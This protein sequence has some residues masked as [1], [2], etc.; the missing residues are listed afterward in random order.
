[1]RPRSV[2]SSTLLSHGQEISHLSDNDRSFSSSCLVVYV[3]GEVRKL[4]A[5][6]RIK[7]REEHYICEIKPLL[8]QPPPLLSPLL[9]FP[10][11]PPLTFLY[12]WRRRRRLGENCDWMRRGGGICDKGEERRKKSPTFSHL[13][14][15]SKQLPRLSTTTILYLLYHG[16]PCS[17]PYKRL[18]PNVTAS[19]PL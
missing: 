7:S 9:P 8:F 13:P 12:F 6:L 10:F 15:H 16:L 2:S 4:R 1:M 5:R 17:R 3:L 18:L 19:S 14:F 11:P